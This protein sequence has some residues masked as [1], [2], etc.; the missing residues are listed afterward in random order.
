[1][2]PWLEMLDKQLKT[3]G[4]KPS[5]L[6]EMTDISQ[7]AIS[8]WFRGVR[9]P[10]RLSKGLVE[11]AL[12]LRLKPEINPDVVLH[13]TLFSHPGLSEVDV[14]VIIVFVKALLSRG[15]VR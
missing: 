4:L 1:M 10:S 7:S 11:K 8:C 3:R 9:N 15:D 6:A 5:Q 2:D 14:G 12:G 13:N